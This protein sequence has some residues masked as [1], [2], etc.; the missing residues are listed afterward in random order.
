M[1]GLGLLDPKAPQEMRGSGRQSDA[2]HAS[3]FEN[4]RELGRVRRIP[5]VA[6]V[7]LAHQE[8]VFATAGMGYYNA[9]LVGFK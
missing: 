9:P 3:G 5:V 4:A 1:N 6:Q 2:F 8:T 7:L